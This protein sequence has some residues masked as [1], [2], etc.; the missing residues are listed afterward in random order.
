MIPEKIAIEDRWRRWR[1]DAE[2]VCDTKVPGM[3]QMMEKVRKLKHE[4][5]FEDV[6]K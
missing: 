4:V 3:K 5:L 1:D 6:G 2:Y